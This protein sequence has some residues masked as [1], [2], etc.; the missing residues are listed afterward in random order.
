MNVAD[1]DRH[2]GRRRDAARNDARIIAAAHVVFVA[3]PKSPMSAV[4]A[5]AGVGIGALYRRYPSKDS[6]IAAVCRDGLEIY[7]S[8]A[9]RALDETGDPWGAL[10]GFMAR[11][12][13]ANI[14]SR[15]T[16]LAG[17]FVPDETLFAMAA[18][19]QDLTEALFVRVR[20]ADLV[21]PGVT[22]NDLDVVG[23]MVA[24]MPIGEGDRAR[25]LRRRYMAL[26]LD[27]MQLRPG[28]S[29]PGPPPTWQEIEARW[30]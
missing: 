30:R 1:I 3:D 27:G 22:V 17:K 24:A 10:T 12:A 11:L 13:D 20:D 18:E 8:E 6:L 14:H 5:Q 21:R 23:E 19:A 7:L 2:S 26:L 15:V 9:R 29:L 4:A 25:T 16:R 28:V